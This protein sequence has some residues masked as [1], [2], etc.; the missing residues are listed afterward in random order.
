MVRGP[1]KTMTF[2]ERKEFYFLLRTGKSIRKIAF[3]MG[4]SPTLLNLEIIRNGKRESYDYQ[5]AQE[6]AEERRRVKN[7][8]IRGRI[9]PFKEHAMTRMNKRIENLE[10]QI[11]ILH[12]TIKEILSGRKHNEL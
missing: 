2:E 9:E 3:I 5:K 10:M 12:E 11:E 8:K 4:R 1:L 6:S 7:E